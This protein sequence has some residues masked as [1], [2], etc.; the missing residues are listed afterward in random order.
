MT[1]SFIT[2][3]FVAVL[4]T[5]GSKSSASNPTPS[6][7]AS[8]G[9]PTAAGSDAPSERPRLAEPEQ[10]AEPAKADPKA[11]LL[12]TEASAWQTARP[13]FTKYCAT[14]HA[15]DGKKATRKKLDHF[16]LATY[17]LGGH[18]T[19][20]IGF[21][22]RDVLGIS[23]KKPTMPYDKPGLVKG[24]ELAAVKAWTDAWEAAE[25]GGAHPAAEGHHP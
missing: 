24:D 12:A 17:P 6:E 13:V 11:E 23:G 16:D 8:S 10:P 2:F 3:V 21:T 5:S 1:R 19:A 7:V 15:K 4:A 25:K 20:T 9:D 14:C 22:I 18:H